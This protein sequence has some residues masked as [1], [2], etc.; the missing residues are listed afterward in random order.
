MRLVVKENGLLTN[1]YDFEDGPIRIGRRGDSQVVL[2]SKAVS[3]EHAVIYLTENGKWMLEDLESSNKTYLNDKKIHKSA[4]KSGDF[5]RISGY[6]IEIDL[7]SV[8]ADEKTIGSG[9]T[10]RLEASLA[11]PPH[12]IL[13]RKPGSSHA[14]AM[15]LEAKRLTEFMQVTELLSGGKNLEE[16]MGA[17]LKVI[18]SQFNAFH[19]W[20]ALREQPSGP[21]T[22]NMGKRRDG[23]E[24]ALEDLQLKD[25]IEQAIER[26]QSMVFPRVSAHLEEKE[27]I[28]SAMIASVMRPAGC[29]GV[30]YVDNAMMQDHYSLSDL[31]YLMLVAIHTGAVL[32]GLLKV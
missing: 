24:V 5:I 7:D 2:R 15:R 23:K 16:L 8:G 11:T 19:G 13:V 21:V 28:R 25:K 26:G 30:L 32:K 27:R 6:E 20:C 12:E 18:M 22:Y 9:D 1:E 31:D 4:I 29:Y 17:L 3:K 10:V 14:P